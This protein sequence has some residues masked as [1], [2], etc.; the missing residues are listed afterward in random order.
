MEDLGQAGKIIRIRAPLE[1]QVWAGNWNPDDPKWTPEIL[2]KVNTNWN[3]EH[4]SNEQDE[5][6]L[7]V[8]RDENDFWLSFEDVM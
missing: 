6:P 7:E 3:N 5:N 8:V 1:K 2:L 4:N